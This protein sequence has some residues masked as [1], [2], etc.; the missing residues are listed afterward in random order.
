VSNVRVCTTG[1]GYVQ[2]RLYKNPTTGTLITGGTAVTVV[3]TNFGSGT[4]PFDGS[5]IKGA[6]SLTITDGTIME[7]W[8]QS[9]PGNDNQNFQGAIILGPG[10]SIGL[11]VKP[12]AVGDI[13][14]A[15]QVYVEDSAGL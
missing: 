4:A 9:A 8:T 12:S 14:T 2:A 6:D 3:N 15:W 10:N 7:N 13:C 11:E 1:S 5:A